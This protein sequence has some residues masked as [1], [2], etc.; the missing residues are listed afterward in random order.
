M[1]NLFRR[2]KEDTG[3]SNAYLGIDIGTTSIKV[4]EVSGGGG[5]P[6]LDN[7]ALFETYG[8]LERINTALQTSTLK[9]YDKEIAE[10]LKLIIKKA[11]FRSRN[12]IVS[13]PAFSAFTTMIEIPQMPERDISETLGFKARQYI[14]LPISSVTIDWIK[15]GEKTDRAGNKIQ[16]I[17]LVS[18]PNEEIEKYKH[19]FKLA[20]VSLTALEMEGFS[21]ARALAGEE[22]KPVLIV[23]IGSRSTTFSVAQE[24]ALKFVSQSDFAGSSLT[25]SLAS[26]LG[27][28][29]RR[30]EDLKRQKG[31]AGLSY[32]P[33]QELST[34][35]LPI[36]DVIINEVE[37]VR[38]NYENSYREKI[39]SVILAG[40]GAG[41]LGIERYLKKR[42][43]LPVSIANPLNNFSYP[44]KLEPV[45]GDLGPLL[46]VALGLATKQF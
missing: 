3:F 7:Y 41:L 24:G 1:L 42:I 44:S 34:L 46:S 9:L 23:D 30:A 21:L 22:K 39:E 17:F 19:I 43:N 5:Q 36:L 20:G 31:L 45:A 16:Q 27:V 13:L 32:A 35:L 12:A 40:G 37:R 2:I 28:N 11:G 10:Y 15:V 38:S 8:H 4:A 18:I 33:E 29:M 25:Q 26:G 14:P 6:H